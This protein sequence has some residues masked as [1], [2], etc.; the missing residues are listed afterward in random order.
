[1]AAASAGAAHAQ[2][3]SAQAAPSVDLQG[4][5]VGLAMSLTAAAGQP[6]A[7]GQAVLTGNLDSLQTRLQLGLKTGPQNEPGADAG[8]WN[9]AEARA[10]AVWTPWSAARVELGVRDANRTQVSGSDPVYTDGARHYAQSRQS[11][12]DAA[13][14]LTPLSPFDLKLAASVSSNLQH[15]VD[16]A[17]SGA[18]SADL[19]QTDA[20]RLSATLSWKPWSAVRLEAGGRMESDAMA[21]SAGRAATQAE[22]DPSASLSL[23]PWSG[24]SWRLSLDRRATP[25]SADQFIGYGGDTVAMAAAAP[26]RE[27][28]YGAA[29]DQK[30]GPLDLSASVLQARVQTYAYLAATGPSA[31]RVGLGEGD[32]SEISAGLAVPLPLPGLAP[33]SLKATGVWRASAVQDPL[34]GTTGRLSGERPYDA[35]LTLSQSFGA[36]LRWGMTA[37]ASGGER[38]LWASQVSSLSSSAGLGG[39]LQYRARPVTVQLSLDNL[40]GGERDQRDV[41][42]AGPRDLNVIDHLDQSRVIDRAVHISLIRPL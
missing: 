23:D 3:A 19:V 38:T 34:T 10:G 35:S 18:Q 5:R 14:T 32:R 37:K 13:A 27:W 7:S 11:G 2:K 21:W 22:L 42:Y 25:L 4:D 9:S 30:A 8:W 36:S 15:S 17:G 40:L 16:V 33:F 29:F 24:A 26:N 31:A 1:L 20:R 6:E 39:F 12:L 28:R 41:F